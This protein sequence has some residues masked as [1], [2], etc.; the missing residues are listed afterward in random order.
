M[1]PT[2]PR[3][4]VSGHPGAVHSH[5]LRA[6]ALARHGGVALARPHPQ[7]PPTHRSHQRACR[8]GRLG[9]LPG[10]SQ[11]DRHDD[12]LAAEQRFNDAVHSARR[13]A[14][15]PPMSRCSDCQE[16]PGYFDKNPGVHRRLDS[17]SCTTRRRVSWAHR[18]TIPSCDGTAVVTTR[19]ATVGGTA[20]LGLAAT[21]TPAMKYRTVGLTIIDTPQAA[22]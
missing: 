6:V 16:P 11:R 15:R 10:V 5:P 13:Q 22:P 2:F 1:T 17:L 8:P 7:P 3:S 14:V 12:F 19:P 4:G 9:P 21:T 18:S 20:S